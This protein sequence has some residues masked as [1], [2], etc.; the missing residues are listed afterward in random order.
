MTGRVWRKAGLGRADSRKS[1]PGRSYLGLRSSAS[2]CVSP[3]KEFAAMEGFKQGSLHS[4]KI[5]LAATWKT[6]GGGREGGQGDH[7]GDCGSSP[8]VR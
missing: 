4:R 8:G 3:A 7:A 1:E 5:P 2:L 6:S